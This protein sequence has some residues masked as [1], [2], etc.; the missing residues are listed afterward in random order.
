MLKL[1]HAISAV[2]TFYKI[3]VIIKGVEALAMRK[4]MNKSSF[5]FFFSE[6]EGMRYGLALKR[7]VVVKFGV[8]FGFVP[9]FRLSLLRRNH[10]SIYS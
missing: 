3:Y 6:I 4:R 2:L 8:F 9:L 10:V 7:E 5:F 1:A